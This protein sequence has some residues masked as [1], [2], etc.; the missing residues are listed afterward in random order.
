MKV[1]GIPLRIRDVVGF[2]F[3]NGDEMDQKTFHALYKDL[4]K[5]CR[6]ELIG[7]VVYLKSPTNADHG[8]TN[9]RVL[10][11]LSRYADSTP[12]T[13]AL[14]HITLKLGPWSEPEPDGC[15]MLTASCG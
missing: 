6:A 3:A 14:G 12:G 9:S 5:E 10:F 4:P 8:R 11:W 7:G 2:P 1:V 13:E 15:L